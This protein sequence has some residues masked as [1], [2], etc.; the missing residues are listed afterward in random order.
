MHI[1][2]K[3][4]ALRSI[5]NFTQQFVALKVGKSATAYGDIERG[6]TKTVKQTR[7]E[8]IAKALD[9]DVSAL[10]TKCWQ[11]CACFISAWRSY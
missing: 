6:K 11:Q 4:K 8:Q 9:I 2:E 7:L 10:F 1:G 5:K 3:I